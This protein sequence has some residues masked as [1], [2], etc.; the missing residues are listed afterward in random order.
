MSADRPA[1]SA[2]V[3]AAAGDAVKQG[4]FAGFAACCASPLPID[5]GIDLLA[6]AAQR[7]GSQQQVERR[8]PSAR[9]MARIACAARTGSSICLPALAPNAAEVRPTLAITVT[10]HFIVIRPC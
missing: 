6:G 10:V 3:R 1:R 9:T 7:I 8:L 5:H 4:C 2:P